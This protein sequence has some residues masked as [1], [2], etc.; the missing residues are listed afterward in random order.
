MAT[1][2]FVGPST[3]VTLRN[4][5]QANRDMQSSLV[6]L[7]SGLRV[8]NAKD[9][10]AAS[11][12]GIKIK[13]EVSAL[14]QAIVNVGQAKS[15]LDVTEGGLSEITKALARMKSLAVQSSSSQNS[16][17]DIAKL[18]QEFQALVS[19]V[20]RIAQATKFNGLKLLSGQDSVTAY[21]STSSTGS[22]YLNSAAGAGGGFESITFDNTNSS[23]PI[24]FTYTAAN[25]SLAG[26]LTARNINTG[27][28]ENIVLKNSAIQIGNTELAR[29]DTLGVTV[30]LNSDFAKGTSFLMTDVA[31]KNTQTDATLNAHDF[32]ITANSTGND[33]IY[34]KSTTGKIDGLTDGKMY[35]KATTKAQAAVFKM[36]GGADGDFESAETDIRATNWGAGATVRNVVLSRTVGTGADTR[37]DTITVSF[38]VG[39]NALVTD[40]VEAADTLVAT[41]LELKNTEFQHQSTSNSAIFNFNAGTAAS[42]SDLIPLTINSIRSSDLYLDGQSLISD[43]ATALSKVESAITAVQSRRSSVAATSNRLDFAYSSLSVSKENLEAAASNLLDLDV[44]SQMAKFVGEQLLLQT[45]ISMLSKDNQSREYVI[46]LLK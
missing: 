15:M 45:G 29:F 22:T 19:E 21:R 43:S 17:S 1:T 10:V 8:V 42:G 20:D 38:K 26:T 7:S 11:A 16:P 5:D 40:D 41:F 35:V 3:L 25:A 34:I 2:Y 28:S 36:V 31:L 24:Q 33:N 32:K 44:P 13:S 39:T 14:K 30:E 9:D 18:D 37:V 27:I 6:K 46:S 12:I 4:L 23:D